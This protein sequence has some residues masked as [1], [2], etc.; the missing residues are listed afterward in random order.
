MQVDRSTPAVPFNERPTLSVDEG[1]AYSGLSRSSLYEL[2]RDHRVRS[3]KLGKRR[4]IIRSS[5]DS[6]LLG[7]AA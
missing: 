3:T 4:L 2:I 7:E 1:V 6:V 5:L